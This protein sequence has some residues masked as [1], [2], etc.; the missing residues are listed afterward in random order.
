VWGIIRHVSTVLGAELFL[1]EIIGYVL[2]CGMA[3]CNENVYQLL[4][5]RYYEQGPTNNQDE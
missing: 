3:I 1:E 2:M 4:I 5:A